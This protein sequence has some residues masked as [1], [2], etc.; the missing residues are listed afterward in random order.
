MIVS[1]NDCPLI[2]FSYLSRIGLWWLNVHF[3]S[4]AGR[5]KDSDLWVACRREHM[6]EG[7]ITRS[8]LKV[9]SLDC[10][11][12]QTHPALLWS[13]SDE[14]KSSHSGFETLG[15]V[16]KADQT[17]AIVD[18]PCQ[19]VEI[20]LLCVLQLIGNGPVEGRGTH[21]HSNRPNR[22]ETSLCPHIH[23]HLKHSW[24]FVLKIIYIT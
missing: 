13:Y 10:F 6:R 19:N 24:D 18:L 15:P 4:W 8:A 11:K 1:G 5:S 12:H 22:T 16:S 2:W 21:S 7:C 9:F 17:Y 23:T 3:P 20:L 14:N